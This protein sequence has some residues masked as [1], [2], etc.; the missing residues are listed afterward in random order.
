MVAL[1]LSLGLFYSCGTTSKS[2]D[3]DPMKE[4]QV[5]SVKEFIPLHPPVVIRHPWNEKK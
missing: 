2:M 1:L 4:E 3:K 5:D